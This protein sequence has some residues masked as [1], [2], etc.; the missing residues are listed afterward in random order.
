[1]SHVSLERP[2]RRQNSIQTSKK[3]KNNEWRALNRERRQVLFAIDAA[4]FNCKRYTAC[5]PSSARYYPEGSS[6]IKKYFG[7]YTWY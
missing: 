6:S 1:M 2:N 4:K 7:M 5:Y 3:N